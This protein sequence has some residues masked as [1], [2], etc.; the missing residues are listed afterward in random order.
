[1]LLLF[2]IQCD[3][4]LVGWKDKYSPPT[5]VTISK[6][7]RFIGTF[8]PTGPLRG[9]VSHNAVFGEEPHRRPADGS[10]RVATQ[11]SQTRLYSGCVFENL[12]RGPGPLVT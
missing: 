11:N 12:R 9:E 8:A 4:D 6:L 7:S 1:M 3:T 5:R 10:T 2:G